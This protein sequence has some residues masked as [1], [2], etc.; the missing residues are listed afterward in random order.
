MAR[1][2]FFVDEVRHGAAE[3]V[4]DDAHHLIRVLRVEAG[5]KYEISD[6][7]RVFLAE[8]EQ[9][10]KS[11][12][13]FRVLEPVDSPALPVRVTLAAALVKFD[14]FEWIVEKATELGV[15]TIVP[16]E[17]DR[18]EKGLL[19]AS[20]K[21]VDR[22]RK[23]ARESSQQSRR[24]R[25]PAI[26]DPSPLIAFNA[27]EHRFRFL[28]DEAASHPLLDAAPASRS[29]E[30][31]VC[32]LVGPE[33]GWT[34]AERERLQPGWTAVSLGPQI[35]RT[36]TAAVAALSIVMSVWQATRI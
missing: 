10:R 8:V 17:T 7:D 15:E 9:A 35:L 18:S 12:V 19:D 33:G 3:I 32:L 29:P 36:E 13:L 20:R 16:V 31:R 22:W 21:R 28:L 26:A 5:Q 6:N 24:K 1:R 4:G 25:L 23:I 2:R 30:D 11:R 14:R 27:R 34:A